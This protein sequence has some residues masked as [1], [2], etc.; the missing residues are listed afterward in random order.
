VLLKRGW[1]RKIV[2]ISKYWG[3]HDENNGY[4]GR[5]NDMSTWADLIKFYIFNQTLFTPQGLL[6]VGTWFLKA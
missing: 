5:G 3:Q 2:R 6:W 1:R 4:A